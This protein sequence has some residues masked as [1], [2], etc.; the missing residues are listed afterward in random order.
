MEVYG[1]VRPYKTASTVEWSIEEKEQM[2][3]ENGNEKST[4]TTF[5]EDPT[6][7]RD[8]PPSQDDKVNWGFFYKWAPAVVL[9]VMAATIIGAIVQS[10]ALS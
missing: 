9:A 5:G 4:G 8:Y 3:F 1:I 7:G 2:T 6:F 10:Y